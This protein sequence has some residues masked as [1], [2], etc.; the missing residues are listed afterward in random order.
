MA[1]V[2]AFLSPMKELNIIPVQQLTTTGC[3]VH[4]IPST[5]ENGEIVVSNTDYGN[6]RP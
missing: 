5:K 4:W 3:G 1:N 6:G 2:A